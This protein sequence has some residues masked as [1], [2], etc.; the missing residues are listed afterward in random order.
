MNLTYPFLKLEVSKDLLRL[1]PFIGNSWTFLAEDITSFEATS[2]LFTKGIQINHIKKGYE[3]RIIFYT[4]NPEELIQT[5]N[6]I[7]FI[8]KG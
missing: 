3:Y 7:G 5:I 1:K 6:E 2:I 8:P 4:S